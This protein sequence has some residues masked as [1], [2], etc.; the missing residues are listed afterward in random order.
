[1]TSAEILERN[2]SELYS[3]LLVKQEIGKENA[4]RHLEVRIRQLK[5]LVG[6][7]EY[8]SILAELEG[9]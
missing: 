6:Q 7:Q 9:L 5:S 2:K 4:S 3:F 1:M 8:Q